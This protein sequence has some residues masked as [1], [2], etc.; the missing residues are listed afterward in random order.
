MTS[1]DLARAAQRRKPRAT[2][3]ANV[4]RLTFLA[5]AGWKVVVS[6]G[7]RGTYHEVEQALLDALDE[8]R[9]RIR[10]NVQLF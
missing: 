5:G 10:N 4:T 1:D 9:G 7:R 6:A 2:P 3:K 8:V